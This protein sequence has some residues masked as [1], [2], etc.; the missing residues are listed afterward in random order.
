VT[1][2]VCVILIQIY[3]SI[4]QF[5]LLNY[6]ITQFTLLNYP[7]ILVHVAYLSNNEKN[8]SQAERSKDVHSTLMQNSVGCF[9]VYNGM[10]M[11]E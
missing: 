7:I 3:V 2:Q 8:P 9:F 4:T 10:C 11:C 6:P 1:K 5:T